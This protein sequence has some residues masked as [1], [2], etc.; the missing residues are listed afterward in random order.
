MNKQRSSKIMAKGITERTPQIIAAEINSIKDQTGRMLLYSSAEIGRRLTEAKS[1]VNHGEWGKWLENSVSYSQSTAN[2]LMRLFEEYEAKLTAGQDSSNSE[3][4][5]NLSYTQAIILWGIPEEERESFM[6]ENDV[7]SMSTRELKQAVQE[8]DQALNEKAELQNAL[9]VNQCA[10]T[11]ITSE[12]DG[13]RKQASGLQA[14]IHTK[15]LTIKTLQEKLNSAKEGEASAAKIAALEKDI[16]A[17][18]IKLSANKV[19]FLYNN[20]AKEFEELLKELTKLAPA[21]PEAHEKYKSEVS[22]LIG[23]IAERL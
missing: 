13:L 19:S 2:K 4:I 17:T 11:E 15:E 12:R 1:M 8:R 20:K 10:V 14:A 9:T 21:D 7:A 16:K 22:G 18:R 6:T 23:K 5:P 3:S